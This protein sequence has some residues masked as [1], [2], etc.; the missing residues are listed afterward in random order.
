MALGAAEV[1]SRGP[2]LGGQNQNPR[3]RRE[4]ANWCWGE[5]RRSGRVSRSLSQ[6]DLSLQL[7]HFPADWWGMRAS[8]RTSARRRIG[9]ELVAGAVTRLKSGAVRAL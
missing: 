2:H 8:C 3:T 6:L 9:A 1:D 7:L 4:A 5:A